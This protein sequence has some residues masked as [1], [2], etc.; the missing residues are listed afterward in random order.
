MT[1]AAPPVVT[2]YEKMRRGGCGRYAL[3]ALGLPSGGLALND[4]GGTTMWALQL[5]IERLGGKIRR[6]FRPNLTARAFARREQSSNN[7]YLVMVKNHVMALKQGHLFNCLGFG[8]A[9]ILCVCHVEIPPE[10]VIA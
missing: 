2:E 10:I 4:D 5:E 8:E 1:V 9:Q 6:Y 7:I 3:M